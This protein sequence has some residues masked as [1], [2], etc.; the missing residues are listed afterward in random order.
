MI[1]KKNAPQQKCP[2]DKY[3]APRSTEFSMKKTNRSLYARS[4][5]ATLMVACGL[6]GSFALT[7]TSPVNAQSSNYQSR[8]YH[9]GLKL[10]TDKDAGNLAIMD[11]TKGHKMKGFGR[12]FPLRTSNY[13]PKGSVA[14]QASSKTDL[15][16][17]G[18]KMVEPVSWQG[19]EERKSHVPS[20]YIFL[21]QFIDHD[22]TLD[23]MSSLDSQVRED[24]LHNRR[25][26]DLDLDNVYGAG[27]DAT[28]YLYNLPYLRVGKQIKNVHS[29]VRRHDL[30]RTQASGK[31][32]PNGGGAVALIGDPRND[33]NFTVSQI[34]AA[35]IAFHNSIV[36][37]LAERDYASRRREFCG[38]KAKTC[39]TSEKLVAR[40]PGSAKKELFEKARDHVIHYY[41]R[42]ISEDFLPRLIGADRSADIK[43]N[44]RIFYFPKGFVRRDGSLDSPY[45]PFEFSVAAYRYGHAMVHQNYRLRQNPNSKTPLFSPGKANGNGAV[46]GFTPIKA[47]TI[48]DWNYFFPIDTK[49]PKGFNF[50][51]KLAP[52]LPVHLHHLDKVGITG[53]AHPSLSE[54][55]LIRGRS[56]RLPSGQSLAR[57]ILPE[58]AKRDIL[59]TWGVSNA[60]NWSSLVIAPDAQTSNVLANAETP[61]WYYILQEAA[62][63][64]RIDVASLTESS[65]VNGIVQTVGTDKLPNKFQKL[66][67]FVTASAAKTTKTPLRIGRRVESAS[68]PVFKPEMRNRMIIAQKSEDTFNRYLGGGDP[69]IEQPSTPARQPA[70]QP[71]R[72]TQ[73]TYPKAPTRTAPYKPIAA[74]TPVQDPKKPLGGG[75]KSPTRLD[76]RNVGGDT[77]GPVGGTVVG[78]VLFGLIEHYRENTGKGLDYVPQLKAIEIR[79]NDLIALRNGLPLRNDLTATTDQGVRYQMRNLLFDAGLALPVTLKSSKRKKRRTRKNRR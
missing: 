61:L 39:S 51:N 68:K 37:R 46:H 44:G 40:L 9:G 14:P 69:Q 75:R 2:Q 5:R 56:F 10:L 19:K 66:P 20:G 43:K 76:L 11:G 13:A 74:P 30:L 45:I 15:G 52:F 41:H 3:P 73:P 63:F 78:E 72:P 67:G 36:N 59:K 32:G 29:R 31:S 12:L 16:A 42:I 54:R 70:T 79:N 47:N 48:I 49:L 25:S 65:S 6:A 34:Q 23:T 50:A 1:L 33:E 58:L 60:A 38:S 77:L 27:P 21:G 53:A 7:L 26:P 35:F 17:L 64:K 24:R 71:A 57:V 8:N 22:I 4:S 18:L 28:P 62:S 55:N